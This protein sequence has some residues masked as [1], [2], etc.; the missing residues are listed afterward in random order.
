MGLSDLWADGTQCGLGTNAVRWLITLRV[1]IA[2]EGTRGRAFLINDHIICSLCYILNPN[3]VELAF[4]CQIPKK[5]I[6][7]YFHLDG[8]NRLHV[9][10]RTEAIN[11][12]GKSGN[13]SG[14]EDGFPILSFFTGKDW[15]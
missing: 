8:K 7:L 9:F 11:A 13:L 12:I 1:E 10:H 3:G 6:Q 15:I 2:A 4:F 5:W 14:I